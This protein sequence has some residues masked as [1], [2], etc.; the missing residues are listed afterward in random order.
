[1]R[2]IMS[3]AISMCYLAV[4]LE[5]PR[6]SMA[7]CGCLPMSSSSTFGGP[8]G[9]VDRVARLTLPSFSWGRQIF[10]AQQVPGQ[11]VLISRALMSFLLHRSSMEPKPHRVTI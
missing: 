6:V 4:A 7:S 9:E 10:G 3:C 2:R 11:R 1:M 5:N 8:L